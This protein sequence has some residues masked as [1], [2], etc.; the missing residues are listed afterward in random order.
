VNH[1]VFKYLIFS[2]ILSFVLISCDE[3]D[4]RYEVRVQKIHIDSL[5]QIIQIKDSAVTP[6]LYDTLLIDNLSTIS[7]KKQQFINQILPAILIVKFKEQQKYDR[8]KNLLSRINL[9]KEISKKD[10][11]FLD[12]LVVRFD[13]NCYDNLL[14][15][16]KPHPTSLVLAQAAVESGW[17]QSRFALEGNN[18]FGI[19]T[20]AY[21]IESQKSLFNRGG[22]KITVKRYK[23]VS[24]SIEHYFFTIG[25][26]QA[27]RSFRLK[28]FEEANIYQ[29][30]DEL[31][32]YS[33]KG[34]EYSK[35]LKQIIIW[36][37][38]RKYDE[39][40]IDENYIADRRCLCYL[41]KKLLEKVSF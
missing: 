2:S 23:S 11:L 33:E 6:V 35:I 9:K 29:L 21:D 27:Y 3:L 13:A 25:K 8:I 39:C 18:L 5:A 4:Y 28:R 38:L 30:I 12:S 10:L 15:R 17:G 31:H 41:T 16:L 32:K 19:R 20:N 26:N 36:N 37:D 40:K 1:Q 14:E 22:G 24:E 34:E 7:E